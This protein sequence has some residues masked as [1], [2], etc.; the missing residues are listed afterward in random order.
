V[1]VLKLFPEDQFNDF[2][3]SLRDP[4]YTY[5]GFLKTVGMYPHFCDDKGPHLDSYTEDEACYRE[6]SM[7]FAHINQETGYHDPNNAIKEFR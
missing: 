3:F 7:M 1:R 4:L 5:E 6:L 2:M